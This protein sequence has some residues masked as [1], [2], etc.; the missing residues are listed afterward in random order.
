M[1]VLVD[2]M[3]STMTYSLLC[4]R[5][6]S[7]AALALLCVTL[8]G[9]PSTGS[10]RAESSNVTTAL[11]YT[12]QGRH[13]EAAALYERAARTLRGAQRDALLLDA[14]RAWLEADQITRALNT[15]DQVT[16]PLPTDDKAIN[17]LIGYRYLRDG[18]PEAALAHLAG[19]RAT[20]PSRY[21]GL[22]YDLRGRAYFQ[23]GDIS[24]GVGAL[25]ERELWL[26]KGD[27]IRRNRELIWRALT[28]LDAKGADFTPTASASPIT[29]G[30]LALAQANA[31]GALDP[32]GRASALREW[33]DA[34]PN[35]PGKFVVDNFNKAAPTQYEYPDT[36]AV[37][38]PLSGRLAGTAAA[39]RDG[40]MAAYLA[41]DSRISRPA[42][43]FY[44]TGTAAASDLA[45][46]AVQDGARFVIGPL[47]KE[48]VEAVAQLPL[49][50]P[51]LA[52]N[53]L[54]DD[55]SG[56]LGLF[57]FS[58]APEHEAA[59]VA[60]RAASEGMTRAVALVPNNAWGERLLT[61]FN[62]QM[63]NIGGEVLSYQTYE[64]ADNDFASPITQL[65]NLNESR[66]RY[67]Q[68]T[69]A[70]GTGFEFEPRR[71]RDAQFIFVASNARQGRLIR[72]ALLYHYA[73]DLPVF[74]T[75]AIFE[76]D[77]KAN[78]RDLDGLVFADMPWVIDPQASTQTVQRAYAQHWPSRVS[79][80]GRLY[81]LGYDAYR[82]IPELLNSDPM[83]E[84]WLGVTGRLS[85]GTGNQIRRELDVAVI[86]G[87]MAEPLGRIEELALDE[88]Q[89]MDLDADRASGAERDDPP[90]Q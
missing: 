28:A 51:V 75:S 41:D 20:L 58:L 24:Q 16:E 2:L 17:L 83:T 79:R 81:A 56:K 80:R 36:V 61:A 57:Q 22:W 31:T 23:S 90:G 73:E 29:K 54:P 72:P 49:D 1:V 66:E 85:L 71:R 64:T 44:D 33:L 46:Q 70:I 55:A 53:T 5:C 15:L 86:R 8:A 7:V 10:S 4:N 25:V 34:H 60:R 27:D 74:A 52:L 76:D 77:P 88:N 18:N 26:G 3:R 14:S 12:K 11:R 6:L 67:R 13:E 63:L 32:F 39:V 19:L 47:L 37:L 59:A 50:V 35:H 69:A 45:N 40:L 89:L 43:R 38:L 42:I 82:M 9:C 87:G 78:G 21:L 62:D 48:Q 68:I 30:W 84:P 65:L